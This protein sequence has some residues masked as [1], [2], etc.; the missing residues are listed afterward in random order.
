MKGLFELY[1]SLESWQY[2]YSSN[3]SLVPSDI[4]QCGV[5]VVGMLIN[6]NLIEAF[7]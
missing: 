2:Y 5:G 4:I 6:S 3:D 1:V 7:N